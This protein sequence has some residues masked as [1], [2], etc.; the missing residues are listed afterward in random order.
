M[1]HNKI[2]RVEVAAGIWEGVVGRGEETNGARKGAAGMRE[3]I[4]GQTL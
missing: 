3:T 2:G 1:M 4:D